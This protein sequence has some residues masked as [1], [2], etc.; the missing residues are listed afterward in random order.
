MISRSK[1][2]FANA[3]L[4]FGGLLVAAAFA[5]PSSTAEEARK[6]PAPALDEPAGAASPEVAVVAGG[7]F[8]GVQGVFQHVDGVVS[9]VSGYD[10]GSK[11][12]AHYEMTSEGNTGHAE[13]VRITYDPRKITYGRILQVFFSV[14]HDPTELNRQG[15]DEGA[16]Y[17]S[18]IFPQ[19]EEQS[20][21]AKAYIGELEQ[22]QA[23]K[24]PIVTTIEPGKTFYPAEGYHQDFMARNPTYPY[25]VFN[26]KPK[27]ES[28]KRL[29]PEL[30][31]ADPVL[32]GAKS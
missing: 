7:C 24:A 16:Q 28:L 5:A 13:S 32:V 18:A 8:W 11:E 29:F 21:V 10:G 2:H 15:P 3:A 25:I 26:D 19:N 27:V 30:Y 6:V 14:A 9:A 23:F 1:S 17:R 4:I 20:R 12:T 22:A 31:R